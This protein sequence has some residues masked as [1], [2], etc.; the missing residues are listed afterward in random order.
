MTSW[1]HDE[2]FATIRTAIRSRR[3]VSQAE[4]VV[5]TPAGAAVPVELSIVADVLP[6]RHL[7]IM[8]DFSEQRALEAERQRLDQ[9]RRIAQR[10][11]AVGQLAAGIAHEI[12]TPIQFIGDSVMFLEG[13][14]EDLLALTGL[15]RDTL[16]GSVAM[17]A[18]ER[19]RRMLDAEEDAEVDYLIEEIPRA[20]SRTT[21]GIARVRTIVRA[22][23]SFSHASV[24]ELAPADLNEAIETTLDVCRNE[25]KYVAD[26]SSE[27]GDVPPVTCNIGELNQVFLNLIIN[28]AQAIAEQVGDDGRRGHITISTWMENEYAVIRFRDNGPGI[29]PSCRSA[30]TSRSSRL[31]RSA[32]GPGRGWRWPARRSTATAA[33][34]SASAPWVRAPRSL[35]GCH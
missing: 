32:K 3:D 30:C 33:G 29:P 18:D 25:Y 31:R 16:F 1:T 10:L 14:V 6:S 23:K 9:E 27:L 5:Q 19:R 17:P 8:R 20:F 4:L 2:P 11:E 24:T 12:N 7:V 21:E 15:Y 13:A 28:S 34:W 26:V 35:S 22:M